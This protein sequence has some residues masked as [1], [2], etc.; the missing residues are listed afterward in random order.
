MINETIYYT[1]MFHDETFTFPFKFKSIESSMEYIN[2]NYLN[3]LVNAYGKKELYRIS[4][5]KFIIFKVTEEVVYMN[6]NILKRKTTTE[7]LIKYVIFRKKE[8]KFKCFDAVNNFANE[9]FGLNE[10]EEL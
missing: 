6:N 2:E 3:E 7:E 1:V 4:H 8:N 10:E 9:D 5:K